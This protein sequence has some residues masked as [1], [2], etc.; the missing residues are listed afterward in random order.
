MSRRFPKGEMITEKKKEFLSNTAFLTHFNILI[1]V[2]DSGFDN[3]SDKN[4]RSKSNPFFTL[5]LK[6]CYILNKSDTFK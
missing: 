3:P 6:C 4:G 2:I 1:V 5:Y